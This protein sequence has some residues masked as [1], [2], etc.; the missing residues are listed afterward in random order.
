MAAFE[1]LG[2]VV[3]VCRACE[4]TY[5]DAGE[6]ARA[7][8]NPA[9]FERGVRA[10]AGRARA[11]ASAGLDGV[12][13]AFFAPDA[14][15]VMAYGAQAAGHVAV[16]TANHV[17]QAAASVDPATVVELTSKAA[18]GAAHATAQAADSAGETILEVLASLFDG[19]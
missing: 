19:L 11:S 10:P 14:V 18:L 5:F 9:A 4:L 2:I 12:D 15:E 6:F 3:D 17:A 7:C 8:S 16:K 1:V 13:L